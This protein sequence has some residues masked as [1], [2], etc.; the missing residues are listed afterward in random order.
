MKVKQLIKKLS[1]LDPEANVYIGD[2][3]NSRPANYCLFGTRMKREGFFLLTTEV[4]RYDQSPRSYQQIDGRL[5]DKEI[6]N[7]KPSGFTWQ[8][9]FNF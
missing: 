4:N 5:F 8:R 3:D 1:E 6:W 7:E 9:C 2:S